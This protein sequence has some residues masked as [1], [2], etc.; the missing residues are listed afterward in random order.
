MRTIDLVCLFFY[1]FIS[2]SRFGLNLHNQE[3]F[4]SL[5]QN[6]KKP[7]LEFQQQ[8]DDNPF[9]YNSF[10]APLERWI[11]IQKES[12]D[13][14][15]IMRR[16]LN[17][18]TTLLI[19]LY[20]GWLAA[21]CFAFFMKALPPTSIKNIYHGYNCIFWLVIGVPNELIALLKKECQGHDQK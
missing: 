15:D 11:I 5:K 19:R 12:L 1:Y 4:C 21:V 8:S 9:I 6:N 16:H 2:C 10:F 7:E 3:W 20:D 13:F 17:V 18:V 14:I